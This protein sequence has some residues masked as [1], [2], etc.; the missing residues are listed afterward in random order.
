[1]KNQYFMLF[2]SQ[3]IAL[4]I[5]RGVLS[6]AKPAPQHGKAYRE[7]S[8]WLESTGTIQSAKNPSSVAYQSMV[9]LKLKEY[10]IHLAQTQLP[11]SMGDKYSACGC[12]LTEVFDEDNGDFSDVDKEGMQMALGFIDKILANEMRSMCSV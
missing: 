1:M 8:K 5:I 12:N 11:I 10:F 2:W 4:A 3:F 9:A 7:F 6:N